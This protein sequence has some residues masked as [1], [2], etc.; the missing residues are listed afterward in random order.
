M[1]T[2]PSEK[3]GESSE[4][5]SQRQYSALTARP[6]V[7]DHAAPRA[8]F[9]GVA[10]LVE[11]R[12]VNPVVGGSSPPATAKLNNFRTN[13]LAEP[14]S[15]AFS[16]VSAQVSNHASNRRRDDIVSL[17]LERD[18]LREGVLAFTPTHGP[19]EP[20]LAHRAGRRTPTT[21]TNFGQMVEDGTLP[22]T[23]APHSRTA[24][25]S[26]TAT[27]CAARSRRERAP[28]ACA[29]RQDVEARETR[30]SAA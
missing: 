28:D 24:S 13:D 27:R 19:E 25:S 22:A 16:T 18:D 2:S 23:E 21:P 11:R 6:R 30:A 4:P 12:I 29:S 14:A 8:E 20:H 15:S 1:A 17:R 10:Q 5:P 3:I 7:S 26:T 9:C